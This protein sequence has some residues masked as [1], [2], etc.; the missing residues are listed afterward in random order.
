MWAKILTTLLGL[1]LMV[2]PAVFSFGKGISDNA[3]IVGPLIVTFSVIAL[4]EATRN[5][6]YLNILCGAWLLAAPWVL[7]YGN[8]TALLNDYAV[9]IPLILLALV[10]SKRQNY[11]AGGWA[12][13]R[14][15]DTLHERK[16]GNPGR[17]KLK[18]SGH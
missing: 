4:S 17:V 2:A 11:F 12:A 7:Q 1:W 6:K 16:A 10:N 18:N 15:S 5:A 3:H 14:G 9:G 8:T 13:L